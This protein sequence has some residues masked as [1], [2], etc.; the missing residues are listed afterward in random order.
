[1]HWSGSILLF[2]K[3][4]INLNLISVDYVLYFRECLNEDPSAVTWAA[5]MDKKPP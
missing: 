1:M 4:N 2:K 5:V 3:S